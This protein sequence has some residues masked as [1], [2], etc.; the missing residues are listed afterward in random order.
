MVT[1]ERTEFKG[2]AIWQSATSITPYQPGLFH[3][4]LTL[5]SQ[6]Y[7]GLMVSTRSGLI[8]PREGAQYGDI[9]NDL[10][11]FMIENGAGKS[12]STTVMFYQIMPNGEFK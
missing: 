7:N 1:I 11:T 8:H 12:G 5:Q 10:L 2:H 3:Y 4:I 6:T 9:Y